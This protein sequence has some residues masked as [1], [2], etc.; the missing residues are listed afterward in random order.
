ME[1]DVGTVVVTQGDLVGRVQKICTQN[2]RLVNFYEPKRARFLV[3]EFE[4]RC[5][6][7]GD[8]DD[9]KR[10]REYAIEHNKGLQRVLSR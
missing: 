5:L 2:I 6:E 3:R 4:V 9:V 8:E 7:A 10:L 1:L